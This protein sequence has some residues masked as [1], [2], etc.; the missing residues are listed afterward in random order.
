MRKL[1]ALVVVL[2]MALTIPA[3]AHHKPDHTPGPVV[4]PGPPE[5]DKGPEQGNSPS[6][7]DQD[8]KGPDRNDEV[9]WGDTD[10]NNGS[11]NDSDGCDDNESS[12]VCASP[13]PSPSSSPSPSPSDSPSP[14]PSPSPEPSITPICV[15]V[16][17]DEG[18]FPPNPDV[19]I[20][21]PS[22]GLTC[23]DEG[24]LIPPKNIER[25]GN[26]NDR[27]GGELAFTGAP[28]W[29]AWGIAAVFA[30]IAGWAILGILAR[31]KEDG[32][33]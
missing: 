32:A 31:R 6:A 2:I 11:G 5:P 26:P 7:P 9:D 8:G 27:P 12:R 16:P 20:P 22:A 19:C 25:S 13:S 15:T 1:S 23:P 18:P 33:D 21:E 29:V 17:C 4:N 14:S 10:G 28:S 30:L 24:K 3:V